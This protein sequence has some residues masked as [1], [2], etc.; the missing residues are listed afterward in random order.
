MTKR[1]LLKS[2]VIPF[3]ILLV[4]IGTH[5]L[6]QFDLFQKWLHLD[7]FL[8]IT[9]PTDNNLFT[10]Q[11]DSTNTQFFDGAEFTSEDLVF[12]DY[13]D[14]LGNEIKSYIE[15][16]RYDDAL[17][18]IEANSNQSGILI[19][20]GMVYLRKNQNQKALNFYKTFVKKHP[21]DPKA[22]FY[23]AYTLSQ[24]KQY[25]L[26]RK[27]Y[28]KAIQ[29]DPAYYDA[30]HNLGSQYIKLGQYKKAI[31]FLKKSGACE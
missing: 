3:A 20:K 18:L 8:V 14:A 2:Y 31:T 22:H 6:N 21:Q 5:V 10:N 19:L 29:L 16:G 7:N 12:D 11:T 9:I 23:Y 17:Q 25:S 1:D 24:M 4:L 13:S 30:Y 28:K 27:H 15:N 26:S